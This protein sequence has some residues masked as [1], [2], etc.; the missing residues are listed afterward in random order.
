MARREVLCIIRNTGSGWFILSDSDH[1]PIGA[2]SITQYSDRIELFFDFT[3]TKV[4]S[5][6]VAPDETYAVT[7]QKR[8]GASVGFTKAIIWF[9]N[10]GVNTK[11]NPSTV[12][13]ASGNFFV[14]GHFS[15]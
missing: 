13:N 5:F 3:A 14:I 7:D 15:D 12:A 10:P 4:H 6:V 8:A 2:T 9:G 11:L 1:Q